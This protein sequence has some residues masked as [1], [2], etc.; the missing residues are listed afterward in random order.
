MTITGVECEEDDNGRMSHAA[1]E[2]QVLARVLRDAGP[3]APTLCEGWTTRD[4]AAHLVVREARP[5]TGPGQLLGSVPVAAQWSEKVRRQYARRD[6]D[7]LV[8]AFA[9]GPPRLSV[10]ALPGADAVA[11]LAE[12]FLHCED[13]R[14]AQ[15]GW[16]PRTLDPRYERALWKSLAARGRLLLRRS[17][18]GV[19]L[20][21]P[22]GPRR[23]VRPGPV[24]V[25][26]TGRPGE[27]LL[28]ASGRGA[29]A[30]VEVSGPPDAVAAYEAVDRS[31]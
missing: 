15:P 2:R 4:L 30:V 22:D 27:L 25:V 16:Q 31:I 29:Q 14:R 6:Y 5:D 12:H 28:H 11:N 9:A 17:P 13:V 7:E 10:F 20:V 19:V 26:V 24:T 21:V 18:V 3:D 23:H 1:A 8:D